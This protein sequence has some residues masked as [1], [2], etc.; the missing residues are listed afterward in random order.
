MAIEIAIWAFRLA[1]W[2]M[3]VNRQRI[4]VVSTSSG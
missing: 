2:P 1:E 3:D 4:G